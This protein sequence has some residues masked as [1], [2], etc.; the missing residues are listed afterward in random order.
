MIHTKQFKCCIMTMCVI[1]NTFC[2]LL[3]TM[4]VWCCVVCLSECQ[5]ILESHTEMLLMTFIKLHCI[6]DASIPTDNG[7]DDILQ[8][9]EINGAV[10]EKHSFDMDFTL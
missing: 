8:S 6:G 10:I 4:M 2:C 7:S 3:G 5:L 1:W 9:I